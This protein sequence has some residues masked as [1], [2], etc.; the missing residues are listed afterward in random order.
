MSRTPLAT[1]H[2]APVVVDPFQGPLRPCKDDRVQVRFIDAGKS[3]V[4]G[5]G[6]PNPPFWD[7]DFG[8]FSVIPLAPQNPCFL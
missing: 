8:P 1:K 5:L 4:W 6:H 3:E 7:D 2:V